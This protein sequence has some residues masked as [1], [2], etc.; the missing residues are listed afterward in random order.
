V[1]SHK[2]GAGGLEGLSDA[3]SLILSQ[4]GKQVYVTGAGD[5]TLTVFK[6]AADTGKLTLVETVKNK[7]NGVEGLEGS[8]YITI[9]AD[10]NFLYATGFRANSVVVFKRDRETGRLTW[11]ETQKNGTNGV[12]KLCGATALA[13]SPNGKQLYV[14]S[15]IDNAL[16]VFSR[17]GLT[18]KLVFREAYSNGRDGVQG[19]FSPRFLTTSA[20]G[21]QIYVSGKSNNLLLFR[22]K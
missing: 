16:A 6:R 21:R 4:D 10:G 2:K 12:D 1:E 5:N 11:V 20:D 22:A 7:S 15:E 18:G 3:Y 13:V 9:S 19:F 8:T 14:A 17:D